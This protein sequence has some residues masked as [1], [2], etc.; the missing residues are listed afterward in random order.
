MEREKKFPDKHKLKEFITT[1]PAVQKLLEG[2][3]YTEEEKII[4][5][6]I[7]NKEQSSKQANEENIKHYKINKIARWWR[8][9]LIPARL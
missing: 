6:S 3:L 8:T 1:N 4:F 9:P 7:G 5:M 2:I